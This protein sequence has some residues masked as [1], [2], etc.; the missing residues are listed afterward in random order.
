MVGVTKEEWSSRRDTALGADGLPAARANTT[1]PTYAGVQILRGIAALL[2]VIFHC[3]L[4][5]QDRFPEIGSRMLLVSGAAGVDVFFP[6]S[7]FVM[8]IST[9]GLVE[10]PDGWRIFAE[11]R[12]IRIVP[13]YWLA[14][15]LKVGVLLAVPALALHS[16]LMPWHTVAS[17][18]FVF[19]DNVEGRPEPV[20]PVGWTLN[21]EIFF[22][23]VF[24][25]T[26]FLQRPLLRTVTA[27]MLL[28][29][30]IG[31]F[32]PKSF[33]P[34]SLFSPIVLEFVAG[35]AIARLALAGR[36]IRGI[37][38][39]GLG[40]AALTAMV[41]SDL[42]PPDWV[43]RARLLVWGVPGALMLF[44][45]VS[46]EPAIRNGAWRLP[47]LI[48]DASYSIY[49]S[50]GFVLPIFGIAIAKTGIHGWAG[51]AAAF[52]LAIAVSTAAGIATYL[53]VERPMTEGL[54]RWR[55]TRR[56]GLPAPRPATTI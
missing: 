8:V 46:L 37:A 45:A 40:L 21:Y 18:L 39:A 2:V 43:E 49:L 24:A 3:G 42:L 34:L 52:L 25:A 23:A 32:L 47:R 10:Y 30:L 48:G 1:H 15:T 29:A 35:M 27:A 13:L 50:H 7:G 44:A 12:L 31:V 17:Y 55:K 5:V 19:A 9:L 53:W 36:T 26:L 11:R 54:M 56:A 16:K 38:A 41:A 4:M 6:I 22:Y 33:A 14:T 51:A 28:V 20:V